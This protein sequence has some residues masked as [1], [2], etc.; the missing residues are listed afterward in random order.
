MTEELYPLSLVGT[1]SKNFVMRTQCIYLPYYYLIARQQIIIDPEE[2]EE[3]IIAGKLMMAFNMHN[4]LCCAQMSGGVCLEYEQVF[5]N[6][7]L[8]YSEMIILLLFIVN[9]FSSLCIHSRIIIISS[10]WCGILF[11][12]CSIRSKTSCKQVTCLLLLL[13]M[14]EKQK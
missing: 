3:S 13:F 14:L 2:K 12:F 4:E 11:T 5:V 8:F 6:F 1:T 10:I 9:Q 7:C